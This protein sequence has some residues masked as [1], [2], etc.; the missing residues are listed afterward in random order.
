MAMMGMNMAM[1]VGTGLNADFQ[2]GVMDRFRT[3]PIARSSVLVAKIVVEVGRDAG[4]HRDPA[5][6]RLRAGLTIHTSVPHLLA[7]VVLSAGL[8]RRR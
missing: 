3:L 7:A 5:G 2:T 8:R 6:H 4:R 1:A